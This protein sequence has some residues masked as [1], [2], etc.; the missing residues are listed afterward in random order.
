MRACLLALVIGLA[1]ISASASCVAG[2]PP[3][4]EDIRYVDVSQSSLTGPLHPWFKYEALLVPA[5]G[6]VPA[7]AD[8]SLSAKRA[9]K[10]LGDFEAAA[11][12]RTFADVVSV[13][14][15]DD[16]FAMQ[17]TPTTEGYIDGPEDS[18]TVDR[19]GITWGLGTTGSGGFVMLNDTQG[20][21]FFKLEDDLRNAIFS[22]QWIRSTPRPAQQRPGQATQRFAANA[23]D[24]SNRS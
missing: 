14:K 2:A 22:A 3:A 11:P 7:R 6:S 4:Y 9:V 5:H 16:F 24:F 18:V 15:A 21:A 23:P 19:C 13:L 1:P 8:V 17:L 12:L 10:F 20:R